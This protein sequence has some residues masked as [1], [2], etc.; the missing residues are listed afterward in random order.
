MSA[1]VKSSGELSY[2]IMEKVVEGDLG[3]LT[4]KERVAY[5]HAR[6]KELGINPAAKPFGFIRFEGT[7]RVEMYALKS[8]TDQLRALRSISL[9][10]KAERQEGDVYIVHC[11]ASTPDGRADEDFGAVSIA[12]LKGNQ[13]ANAIMKAITKAKRRTTL[14]ICGLGILDET[15]LET[16]ANARVEATPAMAVDVSQHDAHAAPKQIEATV[17]EEAPKSE[18]RSKKSLYQEL[19]E[20]LVTASSLDVL[21]A[22]WADV[23]AVKSRLTKLEMADLEVTKDRL[24]RAFDREE[25]DA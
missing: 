9:T 3:R 11:K 6:C 8:C 14:S 25:G 23:Y 2:E 12:G 22:V 20:G 19:R 18:P 16:I 15:E 5:Y 10:I 4:P 13:L 17:M 21:R 1:L 24:K 7:S